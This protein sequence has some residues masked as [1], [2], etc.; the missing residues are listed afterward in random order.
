MM[1]KAKDRH[2][3]RAGRGQR[4][5]RAGRGQE[6]LGTKD[7][8]GPTASPT[9]QLTPKLPARSDMRTATGGQ[10]TSPT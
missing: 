8:A 4:G 10:G 1:P 3:E 7:K 5:G 9:A 6:D 2:A